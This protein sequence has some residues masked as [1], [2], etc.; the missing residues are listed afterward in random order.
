MTIKNTATVSLGHYAL[1]LKISKGDRLQAVA[2]ITADEARQL[3]LDLSMLA[4]QLEKRRMVI[5]GKQVDWEAQYTGYVEL[6]L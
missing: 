3:A 2:G 5:D 6:P 4:E 1:V